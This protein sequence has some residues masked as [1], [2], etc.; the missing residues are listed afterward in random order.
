MSRPDVY[1]SANAILRLAADGRIIL[2]HKPPG[3]HAGRESRIASG[4]A[5][6][7]D[8]MTIVGAKQDELQANGTDQESDV[9]DDEEDVLAAENNPF[10]ILEGLVNHR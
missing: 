3:Y 2:S 4:L 1:R 6:Q 10:D 9:E 5:E 8:R 7:I